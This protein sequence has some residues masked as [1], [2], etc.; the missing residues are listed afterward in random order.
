MGDRCSKVWDATLTLDQRRTSGSRVSSGPP[1]GLWIMDVRHVMRPGTG[2]VS[3]GGRLYGI[4]RDI[5][6]VDL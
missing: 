6:D 4:G 3:Q 2:V 5:T 1:R